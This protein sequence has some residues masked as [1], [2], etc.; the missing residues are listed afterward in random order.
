M[1][2]G[3]HSL[4][5]TTIRRRRLALVTAPLVT[6]MAVGL[7]VTTSG[8]GQPDS[9]TAASGNLSAAT[10]S[11]T[12]APENDD[13]T[14]GTSRSANRAPLVDNRVPR[15]KGKLWTTG[16][17]D[18]RVEPREKS[19]TVGLVKTDKQVAVTGRRQGAYAEVIVNK[20]TRWVTA[21]YLSKTK[22]KPEPEGPD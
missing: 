11:S 1:P 12:D 21:E 9:P 2:R 13:R 6:V 17:L 5:P 16:N 7:G 3:R 14:L 18:L 10:G 20:E 19:K 4:E 8:F 22:E 15:A